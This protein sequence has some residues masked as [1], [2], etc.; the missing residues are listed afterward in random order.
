MN[1]TA[2]SP[3]S[4][5]VSSR[6]SGSLSGEPWC[7]MPFSA[8]RSEVDSSISPIDAET[9]PQEQQVLPG[10]DARVEVRQEPG[11]GEHELGHARQV[12]DR[13]LAAERGQLLARGAVAELGL[14]AEREER[15]VAAGLGAC[16]RD[17]EHLVGRH[18]RA[19]AAPRRLRERAVVADVAAELRQ[20]D[21]D[22]RGVGDDAG[23]ADARSS[24]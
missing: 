15:L 3:A 17:R 8:S 6:A 20:R 10:H 11:L 21:E 7:G 23:H 9:G 12:L 13:R 4:R 22:L 19:L 2:S 24:S 1:G 14:V 16:A 5:I 18:E